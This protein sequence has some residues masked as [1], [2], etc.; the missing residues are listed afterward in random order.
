M[1][2]YYSSY[3]LLCSCLTHLLCCGIPALIGFSSLLTNLIFFES[4]IVKLELFEAFEVY[5]FAFTTSIFIA[6]ISFEIYNRKIR[7]HSNDTC[8]TKYECDLSRKKI[9]FNMIIASFLYLINSSFFLY[10]IIF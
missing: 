2:K 5:F 8:C 6:F 10:E 1:F 4:M 3:A 9:K 7:C